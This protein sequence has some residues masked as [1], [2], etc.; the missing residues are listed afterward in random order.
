MPAIRTCCLRF[1]LLFAL[2]GQGFAVHLSAAEPPI[3]PA[4]APPAEKSLGES[5]LL[6]LLTATL[7]RDYVKD[8]GQLEL[9]SSQP[10]KSRP[11]PDAPLTVRILD[12]PSTGVTSFF[13][14]RF[15][16]LA[17]N[18]SLGAWQWPLQARVWREVWVARAAAQRGELVC[19]SDLA[20]ERRDLLTLHEPLAEF[21]ARRRHA[22][23]SPNPSRP[24]CRCWPGTSN[25]GPCCIAARSP[26]PSSRMERSASP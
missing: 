4:P 1:L 9:R 7:Q 14:V 19:D 8:Q 22:S 23:S 24:E 26:T 11:I 18:Q 25:P 16:L 5:D 17:G 6:A 13:I 12:L 21:T 15:E 20:R 3:S 10:W 2:L